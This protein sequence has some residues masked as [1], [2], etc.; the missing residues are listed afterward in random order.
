MEKTRLVVA[1]CIVAT[2]V[3]ATGALAGP[4]LLIT[5]KLG[6]G[7]RY[8]SN[9]YNS[10]NYGRGVHS[11][12]V[13]PGINLLLTTPKSEVGLDYT[14]TPTYYDD[15]DDLLPGQRK[16]SDSDFLGHV[17]KFNAMTRPTDR[18]ELG[19]DNTYDL[20]RDPDKLDAFSNVADRDKYQINRFTP[21]IM[22]RLGER[23]SAG[24]RYRN[25]Q[26]VYD[27]DLS[28]DNRENRGMFDVVYHF[29][30]RAT[31]DLEYQVWKR[32]YDKLSSDYLSNQ[33]KLIFRKQFHFFNVEAGA[34]F[35]NREFSDPTLEDA[36]TFTY[37]FA[38]EGKNPPEGEEPKSY[39]RAA[40]ESNFNDAGSGDEYYKGPQFSLDGGHIFLGKFYLDLWATYRLSDY[41]ST[42]G[43]NTAGAW[44]LRE[45]NTF[46][47]GGRVGYKIFEPMMVSLEGGYKNRD[48]NIVG[49]S[50]DN[51]YV[52][53]R[54][55]TALEFGRGRE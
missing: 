34:G 14:A 32:E 43:F 18:L 17:F 41:E 25:S 53:I 46:L 8:D 12:L 51:T 11:Y 26:T 4:A 33:A 37:R 29:N 39:I 6:L 24:A 55:D 50:Y 48:S 19:L 28:E 21:R 30:P 31:L 54:V 15:A 40:L 3:F 1:I 52:L 45:D 20:T 27:S 42:Y 47:C 2:L 22:Y 9:F 38:M 13:Q 36:D 10:E 16:A 5:P 23:F 49:Y 7:Y 44:E 35:Q